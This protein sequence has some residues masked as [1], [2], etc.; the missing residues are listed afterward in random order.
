MIKK[1]FELNKLNYE[2]FNFFLLYGKN[3]GLQN[4]VIQNFFLKNFTGTIN[5]YDE[6][7]FLSNKNEIISE[8]LNK[9][10]FDNQKILVI[11]R[12]TDKIINTIEEILEKEIKDTKIILKSGIL[13]KKSKLRNSF[14]KNNHLVTIPFYEDD[15][16]NLSTIVNHF[17]SSNKIKLSRESINL[18]LSRSNGNREFL[19]I[20]LDKILNYSFSQ[21]N[22]NIENIQN[23]TNL[24]ENYNA[25]ELADSYLCK[26]AKNIS[27]ILNENNYSEE[28]CILILRTILNKSKR[29]LS[30]IERYDENG[31]IEQ[32]IATTKPPIFWKDKDNVKKQVNTWKID[33]L[34]KKIYE[35]NEIEFL[36]KTNSGNSLNLLSNFI[37]NF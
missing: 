27:K 23:L 11:S 28:D 15:I 36:I 12:V 20:E 16:N 7:E 6:N 35:I 19:K 31:N 1:I 13:D 18:L 32:I 9:S 5:K 34:K 21:K 25:N 8:L 17:L 2:K 37:I 33:D 29:L 3:L 26:N 10:L 4:E 24:S 22:I 30:I 14:E